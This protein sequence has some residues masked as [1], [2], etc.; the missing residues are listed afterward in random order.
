MQE[1]YSKMYGVCVCV[2]VSITYPIKPSL[3][4]ID[5]HKL[6]QVSH[7]Y[8]SGIQNKSLLYYHY[9][10]AYSISI[11]L[12]FCFIINSSYF[13]LPTQINERLLQIFKYKPLVVETLNLKLEQDVVLYSFK[14]FK[15]VK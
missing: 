4:I 10:L 13:L 8:F 14:E 9:L 12:L 15:P 11:A 1:T 6:F 3:L 7:G 5:T 2:C